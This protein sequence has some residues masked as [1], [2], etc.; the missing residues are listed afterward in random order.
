MLWNVHNYILDAL[1]V[2]A[3]DDHLDFK[4][5]AEIIK[6]FASCILI[7]DLKL[8]VRTPFIARIQHYV[9]KFVSDLW[10]VDG[11][12]QGWYGLNLLWIAL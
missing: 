10:L 6:G 8:W 9:I 4:Q 5:D 11:M 7:F 1:P 12:K 2:C 3:P